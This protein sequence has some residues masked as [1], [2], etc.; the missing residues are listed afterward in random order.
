MPY[1][2]PSNG[3]ELTN[4]LSPSILQERMQK[5][6]NVANAYEFKQYVQ[7]NP[8]L[9]RNAQYAMNN[10]VAQT[11]PVCLQQINVKKNNM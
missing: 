4:Y 7:N 8:T 1:Y 6:L 11:C 5:K 2:P 10:E 9:V 3:R